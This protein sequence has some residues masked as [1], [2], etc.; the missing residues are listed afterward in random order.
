MITTSLIGGATRI[1]G[2]L[3]SRVGEVIGFD[4]V[5][6]ADPNAAD[7]GAEQ[8]RGELIQAIR[9]RLSRMGIDANQPLRLSVTQHGKLRVTEQHRRAAE[10]EAVLNADPQLISQAK[11]LHRASGSPRGAIELVAPRDLPPRDARDLSPRRARDLT[12]LRTSGNILRSS[13][14]AAVQDRKTSGG[15]PNW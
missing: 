11:E 2:N 15:Y 10:I 4:E 1:A 6:R 9:Q 7:G 8:L 12:P 3:A 13:G 14:P 5:L